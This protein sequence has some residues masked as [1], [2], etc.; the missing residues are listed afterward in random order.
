M[1]NRNFSMVDY[2]NRIAETHEPEMAFR[3][4]TR[5]DWS[6]WHKKA[7]AKFMELLGEMPKPA[8]LR[9]EVVAAVEEN[10]VIKERVVFDSEE[11][12]SV[13]CIV[14]RPP[15]MKKNRKNAA[16][17]C[18]HGHGPNGKNP[19]AGVAP[20]ADMAANMKVH[21]YNYGEQ[22]AQ[23]GYLTLC[24]DL[25]VFGERRDGNYPSRDPCN[26]HFV[27][28]AIFGIYTLMLNVFDFTRCVDYLQTRREVDPKRIGLMGLS[29]G[30][31]MATF[32]GA[33]EPRFKVVDIICY[34]NTWKGFGV[35]DANFCGSQIV[36]N[37][38][39]YFDSYDVAS[40]ISPR[41][42]LVEFG[43]WDEG[44]RIDDT[45]KGIKPLKNVYR[46]AGAADKVE[47]E[48]HASGHA[49]GGK[50]AFSFFDEHL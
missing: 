8:P 28:G 3:G 37:I 10:G 46:A 4:R 20:Y 23:R 47:V 30:G 1:A 31:T 36:P 40:I 6:T 7:Y 16:I 14:C 29:Q 39:R 50:R 42:L 2:F 33:A 41:P 5:R 19:V 21:N 25:R 38:Y 34:M 15:D 43:M 18:S 11:H 45:V 24:P 17:V 9:A 27:R 35:R 22:M 48:I 12:M 32:A 26:V 13:P 44:F 49:F